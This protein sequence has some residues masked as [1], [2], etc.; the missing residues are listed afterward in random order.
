M[1]TG[2]GRA[3]HGDT[4]REAT[5]LSEA[6]HEGHAAVEHGTSDGKTVIDISD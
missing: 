5:K 1:L 2:Q 4:L 3:H 6:A